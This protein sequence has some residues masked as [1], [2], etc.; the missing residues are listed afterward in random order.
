MNEA[1]NTELVGHNLRGVR[2]VKVP[3]VV[4]AAG[5]APTPRSLVLEFIDGEK[6]T[7][8]GAVARSSPER[9]VDTLSESFAQQ[10]CASTNSP[11]GR[12]HPFD[13]CIC[14]GC[15]VSSTACSTRTRTRAT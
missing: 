8:P 6:L 12:Q 15:S 3:R 13:A 1:L 5:I 11:P 14:F 2:G 7:S 4:R 10:M 9:L